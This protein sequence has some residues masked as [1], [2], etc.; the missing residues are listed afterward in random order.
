MTGPDRI[1]VVAFHKPDIPHHIFFGNG[2]ASSNIEFM[3][4]DP[5]EHNPFSIEAHQTVFH[6]E[7][8]ESH[9]LRNDLFH[10]S[11]LIVQNDGEFIPVWILTAP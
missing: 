2:T 1:D 3:T 4:V 6:F 10:S 7:T 8:A 11:L 5:P 9:L